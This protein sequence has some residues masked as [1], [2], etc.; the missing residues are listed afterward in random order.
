MFQTLI[1]R[2]LQ[3]RHFWRYATFSE[4][5]ELYISRTMRL[6][7]L[8]MI[9]VFTS[10]YLVQHDY[11][12]LFLALF[13]SVFFG[14]KVLFS[15]PSALI[16]ARIGPKHCTLISNILAAVSMIF[17]PFVPQYGLWALGLWCIFQASST[18]LYDLC[19]LVDFS[20]VK[21]ME[22]AG[23]EIAYMNIFEKVASG[24][25]PV[26]GGLLAFVAGPEVVMILAATLFLV[27]A[28]PLFK[29]GEPT[30]THQKLMFRGFP[31][32]TTWRS[33]V[34]EAAVGYDGF[35]TGTAWTLFMVLVIFVGDGNEVYVKVGLLSSVTLVAA[36]LASYT[37][38]KLIDH[39]RGGELLRAGA[40]LNSF[41][42]VM[43]AFVSTPV[44]VV[45][46]NVINE[47]ATTG[48]SMAF[49]RGMFD[50]ADISGKRIV[51]MSL[52]EAVANLGNALGALLLAVIIMF[53]PD[54]GGLRLF[55]I[56]SAFVTLLIMTPRFMLYRK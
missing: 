39:R 33:L 52:I 49:T 36:L 53:V 12:L 47:T 15:W 4:V 56:I 46:A 9:A 8:R 50:T 40:L 55:F 20:K 26:I 34:A 18:C 11:S 31:W 24:V 25:S 1:Q 23:K 22:H 48:Y 54:E 13:W 28:A 43:R 29:S 10:I 2:L 5:A 17:L 30:R 16:I 19:Y 44:N 3:R 32:R 42:H 38:G 21:N 45:F 27:A 51:Y 35:V 7:A 41:T 6:F 37:F 14:Y